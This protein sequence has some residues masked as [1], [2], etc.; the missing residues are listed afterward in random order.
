MNRRQLL[1]LAATLAGSQLAARLPGTNLKQ[2]R[3][4]ALFNDGRLSELGQQC[5]A[6]FPAN[7]EQ[8]AQYIGLAGAETTDQSIT[9]AFAV[10][11]TADFRAGRIHNVNG[12]IMAEAECALCALLALS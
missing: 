12:W 1:T 9:G 8:L 4:A 11:R 2:A 3:L 6:L 7:P 5:L 10:K